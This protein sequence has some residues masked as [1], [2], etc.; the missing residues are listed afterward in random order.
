[1]YAMNILIF[2]SLI[3]IAFGS[4]LAP[5]G[6][7][8]FKKV[9]GDY[10]DQERFSVFQVNG[11]SLDLIIAV[12]ASESDSHQVKEW[13]L[14]L[15]PSQ[16]KIELYDL[17]CNGW[18]SYN[19]ESWL[20]VYADDFLVTKTTM[21]FSTDP[22]WLY[23]VDQTYVILS[24]SISSSVLYKYND[25]IQVSSDWTNVNYVDSDWMNGHRDLFDPLVGI[26]RYY[27]YSTLFS[28]PTTHYEL[29]FT[30]RTTGGFVLYGD[31]MEL[32]R[33]KLPTGVI[34]SSTV[35]TSPD[36]E[37]PIDYTTTVIR[38]LFGYDIL[39][40]IAIEIHYNASH[41]GQ[42]D[43]FA[44]IV[45]SQIRNENVCGSSLLTAGQATCS[46]AAVSNTF[47]CS[48]IYESDLSYYYVPNHGSF[49]TI[50]TLPST[51]LYWFNAYSITS[52]NTAAYGDPTSWTLSASQDG[53]SW[54]PLD[55]KEAVFTS[56]NQRYDYKL[57]D[58]LKSFRAVKLQLNSS[59]TSISLGSF[60]VYSCNYSPM[61]GTLKYTNTS[62]EAYAYV[63]N[64]YNIP[65]TTGFTQFTI[66]P[67]LPHG[68]SL[69]P[70]TGIISGIP[71]IIMSTSRYMITAHN[72]LSSLTSSC[73]VTIRIYGCVLPYNISIQLY[74][75]YSE[76]ASEESFTLKQG[77]QILYS[78]PPQV[79]DST[80]TANLCIPAGMTYI[81]LLDSGNN[82]WSQSSYLTISYMISGDYSPVGI[83][84]LPDGSSDTFYLD[85]T[86][87]HYINSSSMK[88][89][90]DNVPSEWY[91]T[92]FND[93]NWHSMSYSPLPETTSFIWLFRDKV[94]YTY[95]SYYTG[96]ELRVRFS[97][98][99]VLY[100]NGEEAYR[101]NVPEGEITNNT[102]AT[103]G[104]GLVDW[105]Y[106][107]LPISYMQVFINIFAFAI[108]GIS[109]SSSLIS[110]DFDFV[111]F[112][113]TTTTS[114]PRYFSPSVTS[115]P[116]GGNPEA[117]IDG[118]YT[119]G[120]RHTFASKRNI[121]FTID[122]GA[123]RSELINKLCVISNSNE[124]RSDPSDWIL[125]GS[126]NN[127]SYSLIH[128]VNNAYFE[129]R[130]QKRCFYIPTQLKSYRYYKFEVSETSD[131][132]TS[133]Y[134]LSIAE[135]ELLLL[136]SKMFIPPVFSLSATSLTG[137]RG[138]AFPTVTPSS[139]LY[140][141]FRI[142]PELP[143]PLEIDTT[144]GSIRGIPVELLSKQSYTIYAT[145]PQGIESHVL[146]SLEV[147]AC[148][149]PNIMFT[150][151]INGG[152]YGAEQGFTLYNSNNTILYSKQGV[153]SNIQNVFP[154]CHPMDI[155][156]FVVT[157]LDDDGWNGGSYAV[158]LED[159][160]Q[161]LSGS[162]GISFTKKEMVL[163]LLYPIHP[164]YSEWKTYLA[165]IPTQG[166][167]QV[168]FIDT[169]W[170]TI[171]SD[172]LPAPK[173]ITSYYRHLFNIHNISKY[174]SV[175]I[176]IRTCVGFV[177]YIN[178]QEIQRE[179]LP[180]G[181]I[182]E[183]IPAIE[184][185]S[186]AVTYGYSIS[187]LFGAIT[188]G[189][190]VLCI[191]LHQSDPFES[192]ISLM[193]SLLLVGDGTSRMEEGMLSS[194]IESSSLSNLM[195]GDTTT[196]AL[197]GPRC[198]GATYMYTYQNDIKEYIS[199]Y[200]LTT[201]PNCNVR[202]PSGW[203]IEGSNDGVTW[204]VLSVVDNELFT[205]YRESRDYSF[206]N[207]KSFSHYRF[208]VTNCDNN[209]IDDA[210]ET[211]TFCL[212]DRSSSKGIQ[213][214]ELTLG[215]KLVTHVCLPIDGFG[216]ALEG[217][218]ALKNCAIYYQGWIQRL[219]K[220]GKLEEE[221][222]Y[223]ALLAPA[224][225]IYTPSTIIGYDNRPINIAPLVK[226]AEYSC[227]ITPSLPAG[228]SM[229]IN[230]IISGNPRGIYDSNIYN[231]TCH[232]KVG[233][234][235]VSIN[236][237]ILPN[238]DLPTWIIAVIGII[239]VLSLLIIVSC[240]VHRTKKIKI[241]TKSYDEKLN[242]KLQRVHMSHIPKKTG[243]RI[244][245]SR[246]DTTISNAPVT[247]VK[248]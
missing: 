107:T 45:R 231:V 138:I 244:Q 126:S 135:I 214:A 243:K 196:V 60:N 55:S 225:I 118:S 199:S 137:Y 228:L 212:Y 34:N 155:Y 151:I 202:H 234:L 218:Y 32:S 25:I 76:Y 68:L 173:A 167:T 128:Q 198:I 28:Q 121:A 86:Y 159:G 80:L 123:H 5:N 69:D 150:I 226:A 77:G 171:T 30:I 166:W 119:N 209:P 223:C 131:P 210:S 47:A 23:C 39:G 211:D 56:R 130:K 197:S 216:G 229:D 57:L 174:A 222:K 51:E 62:M 134:S 21:P 35:T 6:N 153:N 90:I 46:Y 26:T 144:T 38:H 179:N 89:C 18:G 10:A 201:G 81:E 9:Y 195:D 176:R 16:Y 50:Y 101:D 115:T 37:E 148:T 53:V 125:Y 193:A 162:L 132:T 145:S 91:T 66:D 22:F 96:M 1:M 127:L 70:N 124:P 75:T 84:T 239:I 139:E 247:A 61:D 152:I 164:F 40:V 67:A 73:T 187:I 114:H 102:S 27:R 36:S 219:C 233:E 236:L 64:I 20:Y 215:V 99:I 58:N 143:S 165:G 206:F 72:I 117:L 181:I 94:N 200:S 41:I 71:T 178:G 157:D 191:E 11:D 33:Q 87:R 15:P 186:T 180:E 8:K 104:E 85:A 109:S 194:D 241:R 65:L 185:K 240:I 63:T 2:I 112:Y 158:T 108:I 246:F 190:N 205:T 4:C 242:P 235:T 88:Y 83:Y 48:N 82:G 146:I 92:N 149:S 203:R 136:N 122:F 14:C 113:L 147:I 177:M 207:N 97:A 120:Y 192:V 169:T 19:S 52:A 49:T 213:L 79:S 156:K 59:S 204:S 95:N 100:I 140:S 238:G 133:P 189:N 17:S 106:I 172:T 43:Q 54:I 98:G 163:S 141:N 221:T 232:N 3:T 161:I 142:L 78:S 220:E 129:V 93:E 237:T 245:Q 217:Q 42:F 44:A 230:G 160:T 170:S 13:T 31:S 184:L 168:T 12:E 154:F 103:A 183:S 111:V 116:Y 29:L 110:L 182:T 248:V 188:A 175:T 105:R 224:G 208:I 74:K 227:S 24:V 7:I